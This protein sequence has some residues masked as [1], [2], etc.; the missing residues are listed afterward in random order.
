[1][2]VSLREVELE[3]IPAPHQRL[4][5]HQDT[6]PVCGEFRISF[7]KSMIR[8]RTGIPRTAYGVLVLWQPILTISG[9]A[10]CSSARSHGSLYSVTFNDPLFRFPSLLN[11]PSGTRSR[12]DQNH[13]PYTRG[14]KAMLVVNGWTSPSAF[15]RYLFIDSIST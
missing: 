12:C 10:G 3:W 2:Q 8:H 9:F 5:S 7:E 15:V 14:V 6:R 4:C 1:M 13:S 11:E